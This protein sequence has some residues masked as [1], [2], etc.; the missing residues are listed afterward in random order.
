M[1]A[2]ADETALV[3]AGGPS[4][5]S[6]IWACDP[7]SGH[8]ST[9]EV[10]DCTWVAVLGGSATVFATLHYRRERPPSF[11]VRP[12]SSPATV[13]ARA[14][15]DGDGWRFSGDR[16]AWASLP[17]YYTDHSVVYDV[18]PNRETVDTVRLGWYN[19]SNYD[20]AHQG[21]VAVHEVL[22][23]ELLVVAVQRDSAPVLH[24]PATG[25]PVGVIRL[26]D[27]GGNPILR[28]RSKVPELWACDYDT[29]VRVGVPDW[30]G[31]G[32]L[33]LE[34]EETRQLGRH[35]IP[36]RRFLGD[37]AFNAGETMCAVSRPFHGDVILVETG[38]FVPA[39]RASTGG[40]PVEVVLLSGRRL[41]ARDGRTGGL[42]P[43]GPWGEIGLSP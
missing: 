2:N 22:G 19:A 33:Q 25:Q 30:M 12:I 13:L 14:D 29:L 3:A 40:W 20:L 4:S 34:P 24:D 26:A 21:I 23:Q 18:D 39:Y 35:M 36:E 41:Y 9:V 1:L 32:L 15:N 6:A 27:R 7:E 10:P 37:L 42:L 31:L 17:R 5:P 38:R 28:F 43:G 8:T 16:S 11:S